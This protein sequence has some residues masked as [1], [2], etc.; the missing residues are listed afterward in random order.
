[1][2]NSIQ[3]LLTYLA[4]TE[5]NDDSKIADKEVQAIL[6]K[7]P[8]INHLSNC[9]KP[10]P[11]H[12]AKKKKYMPKISLPSPKLKTEIKIKNKSLF[13]KKELNLEDG[14][15][16]GFMKKVNQ[17]R[18]TQEMKIKK[19]KKNDGSPFCVK[20]VPFKKIKKSV[21]NN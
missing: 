19:R 13:K 3:Q 18:D 7:K 17:S 10:K 12:L 8:E 21:E 16:F 2:S 15:I 6:S 4:R 14:P 5:L 1:M 11:M 9:T 20:M